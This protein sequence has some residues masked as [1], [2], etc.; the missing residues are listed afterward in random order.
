MELIKEIFEKTFSHWEIKFPIED[1]ENQTAGYIQKAGWLIQYCF[2]I[3]N[4]M[5]YLD[6]YAE[7]HMTDPKHHRIY[8]NGETKDLE[9]LWIGYLIDSEDPEPLKSQRLKEFGKEAYEKHNR[10]VNRILTEKGFN[11]ITINRALGG[12]MLNEDE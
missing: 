11:R 3:E 1:L 6:Y 10:E 5:N 2:G 7:N 4:D 12:C 8:A 9:Y